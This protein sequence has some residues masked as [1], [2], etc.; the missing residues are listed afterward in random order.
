MHRI[1]RAAV[2][3]KIKTSTRLIYM[4]K[5]KSSYCAIGKEE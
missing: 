3:K 5:N 1:L 4:G 2:L